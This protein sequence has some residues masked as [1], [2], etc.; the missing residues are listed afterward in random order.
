MTLEEYTASITD[1][2]YI[3][4]LKHLEYLP[5][6]NRYCFRI[7]IYWVI[8]KRTESSFGKGGAEYYECE[9]GGDDD[10]GS[11]LYLSPR[12]SMRSLASRSAHV[13]MLDIYVSMEKWGNQT[14]GAPRIWLVIQHHS[15]KGHRPKHSDVPYILPVLLHSFLAGRWRLNPP[16]AEAKQWRYI[17]YPHLLAEEPTRRLIIWLWSMRSKSLWGAS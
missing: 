12:A 5:Y 7:D 16:I 6:H 8:F 11:Y 1:W 9:G 3:E 2:V 15:S 14:L 17:A 4:P 10:S 13:C